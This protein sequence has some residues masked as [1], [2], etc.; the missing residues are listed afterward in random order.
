MTTKQIITMLEQANTALA[1]TVA[2]AAAV[3]DSRSRGPKRAVRL[4]R[5]AI[6]A[7]Q[8]RSS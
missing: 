3:A 4:I 2:A 5:R 7:L 1:P 6:E 8:A